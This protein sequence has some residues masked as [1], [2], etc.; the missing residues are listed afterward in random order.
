[1]IDTISWSPEECLKQIKKYLPEL[2]YEKLSVLV[3]EYKKMDTLLSWKHQTVEDF[4]TIKKFL[5]EA[6]EKLKEMQDWSN[7]ITELK[8]IM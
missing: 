5:V 4:C 3:E 1:M 8:F 2:H 7:S 6:D